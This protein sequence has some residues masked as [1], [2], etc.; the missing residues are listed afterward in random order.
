M[1]FRAFPFHVDAYSAFVRNF[2]HSSGVNRS[3]ISPMAA[4]RSVKVLAPS[5]RR[6]ALTFCESLF[7]GV[8]VRTVGWQIQEPGPPDHLEHTPML[9]RKILVTTPTAPWFLSMLH[10]Q[11]NVSPYQKA[12]SLLGYL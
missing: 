2:E 3:Q 4:E 8:Q 11:P 9:C 7:D 6:W 12:R 5:F 10:V 1:S